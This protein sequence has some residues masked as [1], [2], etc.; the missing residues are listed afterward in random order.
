MRHRVYGYHLKRN[1]NER[2]RLF[3]QL[4]SSFILHGRLQTTKAKAS[5]IQGLVEGLVTLAQKNTTQAVAGIHRYLASQSLK[6]K[7]QTDIVPRLGKSGGYTRLINLGVRTGDNSQVALLQWAY[8]S[9]PKA[10]SPQDK[11]EKRP[12]T[13]T[14]RSGS[15]KSEE[16]DV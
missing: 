7:F 6:K 3:R 5:A 2:Q 8:T 12:A 13:K 1:S 4:V 15:K 11:K 16:K 9:E 10:L 14:P